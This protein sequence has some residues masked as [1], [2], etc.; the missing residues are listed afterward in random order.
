MP[1]T[2]K[3]I[4]IWANDLNRQLAEEPLQMANKHAKME[5]IINY[6]TNIAFIREI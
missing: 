3:P 5:I 6:L 1:L 2:R 4:E